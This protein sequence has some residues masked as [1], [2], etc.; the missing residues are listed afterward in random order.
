MT[1]L[2][3]L[4]VSGA[5][6]YIK[7]EFKL[8][9]QPTLE[10]LIVATSLIGAT[11]ITT[12]S[13]AIADWLGRR[14]LLIISSVLYFV[15]GIVMLWAP[16]VYVLLLAR[17][18]DGFGIGLAVTLVPVYISETAP[19]EIR[20]LLNTLPQF[21]GSVGMFLSYCMV[22]GMSLMQSPNWRLMLGVLSIPSV[23][24]FL[25]TLFFLPESP[26]WL[27]SKGRMLEAKKVLQRLRGREDVAG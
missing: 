7:K 11:L 15:S 2:L 20:G 26:R 12:C 9:S 19:P 22:F 5:V 24:F 13:G 18:L 25:L 6:L 8:E 27:V 1:L 16:N 23:I 4:C 17:L 3:F 14:P 10:G 21:T